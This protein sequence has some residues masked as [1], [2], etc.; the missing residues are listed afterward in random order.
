M[1]TFKSYL[2]ELRD[3]KPEGSS[4]VKRQLGGEKVSKNLEKVSSLG[5]YNIHKN[6]GHGDTA[7]HVADKEGNIHLTVSGKQHHHEGKPTVLEINGLAKKSGSPVHASDVYAHLVKHHNLTL[8]SDEKV[9]KKGLKVWNR[10]HDDHPDLSVH[11]SKIKHDENKPDHPKMKGYAS[12]STTDY[13]LK[14]FTKKVISKT[15]SPYQNSTASWANKP[16]IRLVA[17]S[18]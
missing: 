6:T 7:Y 9:T 16:N 18:K 15:S 1:K 2:T 8:V 12:N 4:Y 5:D 11:V 3:I 14:H 10:L 13:N 17:H